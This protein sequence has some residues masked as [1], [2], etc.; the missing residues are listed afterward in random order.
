MKAIFI[1]LL[2]AFCLEEVSAQVIKKMDEQ[3]WDAID[4]ACLQNFNAGG[5]QGMSVAVVYGGNIAFAK[6]Y[7]DRN[8]DGDPFTIYTKS[9]LASV[10]KTIT[11]VLAMRLVENNDINLGDAISQY[12]PDFS[13]SGITIRHLLDHQSGIG[14]YDDCPGGYSGAFNVS[15]SYDVVVDCSICFT[16]PGSEEVY[17]TF[18]NT[19]LGVIISNVG[20]LEYGLGYQGL[21][22]A[23]MR[24]PG[25]LGTL[26][27]AF[28]SSDPD[29]A[30]GSEGELYWD[31]IG[32]KLPAGGFISDI[33]DLADY[34]RGLLNNVFI[35]RAT[36][37]LMMVNQGNTGTPTWD[38]DDPNDSNDYGLAFRVSG[39][40]ITDHGFFVWHNG[41]NDHGYSAYFAVYPNDNGA[42]VMM[43]NTGNA[44]GTLGDIRND[45]HQLLFC[46]GTR[47]FTNEIDWT[48]PRIFEASQT[49]I[50]RS[51]ISST[52]DQY[53]FDAG[54]TVR[55]LPGFH[56][57]IGKKFRATIEGCYGNII[58]D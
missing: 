41:L 50:G 16:P 28:D 12:L 42:I 9:L 54:Q 35:T 11:G 6:G 44:A 2:C 46:A 20:V 36:F 53:I 26:E 24:D 18:G 23:W 51:E 52:Y 31:D 1:L 10:S 38:C 21:Y 57:G 13:G 8:S 19:L 22:S 37:D 3:T 25:N 58:P 40:N 17:T 45:I 33:V 7:G 49:I 27:P 32:W 14:H 39:G 5:L 34:A 48:E 43:T 29:L 55:C 30:E 4:A 56:V 47:D 15:D